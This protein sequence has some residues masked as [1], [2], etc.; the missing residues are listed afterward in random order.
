MKSL[1]LFLFFTGICV[2]TKAQ[3]DKESN[4]SKYKRF[5]I[6]NMYEV[7]LDSLKKSKPLKLDPSIQKDVNAISI[8]NAYSKQENIMY[9]MPIKKVSG[10]GLAPMPGTENLDKLENRLLLDSLKTKK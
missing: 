7:H 9:N 1:I 2:C 3:E 6:P 10:K 4:D 5:S 8:P